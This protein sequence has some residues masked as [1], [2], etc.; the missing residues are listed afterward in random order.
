MRSRNNES[1]EDW[2]SLS[3]VMSAL[4]LV[5]LFIAILFM[6]EERLQKDE[7]KVKKEAIE[8]IA[9]SFSE[10]QD[11]LY[12]R[13]QDTFKDS[14]EIWDAHITKPD[15]LSIV[16]QNPEVLFEA[17]KSD[18]KPRFKAVLNYFWPRF[19]SVL[20]E[21][22]LKQHIEEIRIEGHTSSEWVNKGYWEAYF[23]NMRLSQERTRTVLKYVLNMT[24]N[25]TDLVWQQSLVTANGLSSSKLRKTNVGSEDKTASRRVEFKVRTTAVSEVR[26]ILSNI[27]IQ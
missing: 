18:L 23:A 9:V 24:S 17:G 16:F 13:L 8:Q 14:L 3:D 15:T 7:I 2:I 20:T 11:K 26:K 19:I 1:G 6:R 21:P 22:E 27:E 12:K 10:R 4:M 25:Q 5:F